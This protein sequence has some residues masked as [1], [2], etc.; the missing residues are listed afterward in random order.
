MH[1]NT[2]CSTYEKMSEEKLREEKQA[3]LAEIQE[4]KKKRESLKVTL[5]NLEK[6]QEDAISGNGPKDVDKGVSWVGLI[7]SVFII[8]IGAPLMPVLA[9]LGVALLLFS[10]YSIYTI[11]TA[12]PYTEVLAET[13]ANTKTQYETVD[14]QLNTLNARYKSLPSYSALH[15]YERNLEIAKLSGISK[16]EKMQADWQAS[17][18]EAQ[19]ALKLSIEAQAK[20]A[21]SMIGY[22]EQ[23]NWAVMGG[24]AS[25][26]AGPVAGI[27]N[28]MSIQAEERARAEQIR[29]GG[30]RVVTS[31][32][33]DLENL[34]L[35]EK[36][37]NRVN[38]VIAR[39]ASLSV[40]SDISADEIKN[41][42][43]CDLRIVNPDCQLL[44]IS[45]TVVWTKQLPALRSHKKPVRIDGTLQ[46]DVKKDNEIVS[47]AYIPFPLDG[48]PYDKNVSVIPV[49]GY[50]LLPQASLT[51]PFS[52][53]LSEKQN[54][55]I[56][57]G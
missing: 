35:V 5:K 20:T 30:E 18:I 16:R 38:E 53:S 10:A 1:T 3:L 4:V 6:E 26:I 44:E 12:R 47:T 50:S 34:Q 21:G 27:A 42:I 15:S 22:K 40:I 43:S 51:G 24:I 36:D 49:T 37:L 28:A 11:H 17:C 9:V 57:E 54:L 33:R 48:F 32:V 39:T 8:I 19:R 7:L 23:S 45:G 29:K 55:W 46:V 52:I 31:M 25:G 2:S 56:L 41:H 14:A 13:I